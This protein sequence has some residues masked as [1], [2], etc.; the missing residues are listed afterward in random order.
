MVQSAA[1]TVQQFLDE[2]PGERRA[3]I[4]KVRA[5]VRKAMPKG[6][7]EGMLW[8]ALCWYI[9]LKRYPDTYNKQPL[10]YVGLA[11]QKN[12]YALYLMG[13][14]GDK[15]QET[16][17]KAAYEKIGRKPDMGKSCVRF[18]KLEDLPLEA[19]TK[20]IASMSVEDYLAVYEKSRPKKK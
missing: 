20:L 19:I 7:E 17:L 12:N 8:G 15:K 14:Y 3:V 5:A 16:A 6:Y 2:L 18:R 13:V 4:A 9:P 11:A 10:G 1:T